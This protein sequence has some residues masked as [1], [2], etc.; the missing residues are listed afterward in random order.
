MTLLIDEV[1]ELINDNSSNKQ[2][3]KTIFKYLVQ[4]SCNYYKLLK[5]VVIL[6]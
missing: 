5:L 1:L 6:I 3:N 4:N 2:L